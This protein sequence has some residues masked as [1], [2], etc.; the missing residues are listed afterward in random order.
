MEIGD[1]ISILVD[2]ETTPQALHGRCPVISKDHNNGRLDSSDEGWQ[3]FLSGRQRSHHAKN[4]DHQSLAKISVT[5]HHPVLS[6]DSGFMQ[7]M[8]QTQNTDQEPA[9][10]MEKTVSY[11][12]Y[13][14]TRRGFVE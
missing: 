5:V 7:G 10:V 6:F 11:S 3:R 13:Y 8:L 2:E 14:K 1:D 12:F 4:K 9:R